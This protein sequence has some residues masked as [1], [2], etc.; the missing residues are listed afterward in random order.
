M[1]PDPKEEKAQKPPVRPSEEVANAHAA[2]DGALERAGS[3]LPAE[4]GNDEELHAEDQDH[5]P[6]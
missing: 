1:H 5:I 6:Y 2:G 4:G 3:S